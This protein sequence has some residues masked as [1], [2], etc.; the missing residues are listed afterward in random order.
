MKLSPI[1]R[2]GLR[3]YAIVPKNDFLVE[4]QIKFC[5]FLQYPATT[6]FYWEMFPKDPIVCT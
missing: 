4:F 1:L 5:H 3:M 6:E 2:K